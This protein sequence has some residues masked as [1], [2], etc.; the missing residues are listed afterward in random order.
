MGQNHCPVCSK[1]LPSTGKHVCNPA[2]LR[3][4]DAANTRALNED[5]DPSGRNELWRTEEFRLDEGLRM[6]EEN[7]GP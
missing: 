7:E 4:I 6:M 2:S 3:A 5:D 1:T